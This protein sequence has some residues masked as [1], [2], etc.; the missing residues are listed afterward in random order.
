LPPLIERPDDIVLL[1]EH[2]ASA[3]RQRLEQGTA[4]ILQGYEWPGNVRELRLAIER[5]G[6]LVTN[7]TLAPTALRAAIELGSPRDP[8]SDRRRRD[9]RETRS[10]RRRKRRPRFS[11]A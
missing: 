11:Y 4:K 6:C 10:D 1:A 7:G 3:R 8:R 5:A 2:F 9:R